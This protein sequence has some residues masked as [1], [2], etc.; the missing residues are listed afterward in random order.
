MAIDLQYLPESLS[1]KTVGKFNFDDTI[2]DQD[3]EKLGC[4]VVFID[5]KIEQHVTQRIDFFV[6][7]CAPYLNSDYVEEAKRALNAFRK[8]GEGA[9]CYSAFLYANQNHNWD[10]VNHGSPTPEAG[11][12]PS[13]RWVYDNLLSDFG[14]RAV[15][16]FNYSSTTHCMITRLMPLKRTVMCI[17]AASMQGKTTLVRQLVG[18]HSFYHVSSDY[19]LDTLIRIKEV[20]NLPSDVADLKEAINKIEPNKLWGR[21][22]RLLEED[23]NLLESFLTLIGKNLIG[24]IGEGVVS[25]DIDI[26]SEEKQAQVKKFFLDEG[27]KVWGCTI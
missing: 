2:F 1:G 7:D 3:L 5:P 16:G 8:I 13:S 25:F 26:R 22:F 18:K 6:L 17:M 20:N 10:V 12:V 19:L 4:S 24:S 11:F 14:A 15:S 21:F 9:F 23:A 27:Y